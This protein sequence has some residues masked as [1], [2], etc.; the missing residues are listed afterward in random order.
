MI[1]YRISAAVSV[2]YVMQTL[3]ETHIH[4]VDASF[5]FFL[6]VSFQFMPTSFSASIAP[7]NS[8]SQKQSPA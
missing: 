5:Q 7:Y 8:A 3:A 2:Q 4:F 6:A 1:N